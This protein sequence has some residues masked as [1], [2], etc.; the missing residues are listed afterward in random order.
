MPIPSAKATPIPATTAMKS[1]DATRPAMNHFILGAAIGSTVSAG[2]Y[3]LDRFAILIQGKSVYSLK[4]FCN[5]LKKA[6]MKGFFPKLA[7]NSLKGSLTFGLSQCVQEPLAGLEP[8]VR[9]TLSLSGSAVVA[10][11]ALSPLSVIKAMLYDQQ[12]VF[13]RKDIEQ[14]QAYRGCHMN[15]LRDASFLGIFYGCLPD[16]ASNLEATVLS[17]GTALVSHP[18]ALIGNKQKL[19]KNLSVSKIFTDIY[20][21]NGI[22]GFWHGYTKSSLLQAVVQGLILKQL[23]P[24]EAESAE[25]KHALKPSNSR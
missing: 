8:R 4:Q 9:K 2:T 1:S 17:A 21:S 14:V 12:Q 6:P 16:K 13:T 10:N 24:A 7:H 18:F 23:A 11:Y 3:Y 25:K 15:A 5:D 22:K 19:H 20:K